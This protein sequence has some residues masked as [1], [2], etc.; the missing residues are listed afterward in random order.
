MNVI[1]IIF[2]LCL[3][4]VSI[5]RAQ[6]FT[7]IGH[8]G[9]ASIAPE[10]TLASF[11][12][13]IDL[14]VDYF[15]LDVRTTLDDSLIIMHDEYVDRTTNGVGTVASKTYSEIKT[16]DAGSKFSS[17]FAGEKVP[18]LC[19][20]LKLAKDFNSKACLH[21]YVANMAKVIELVRNMG[22]QKSVM[23]HSF[24]FSYLQQS[25]N[26]DSTIE[27]LLLADFATGKEA[28]RVDSIHGEYI[29]IGENPKYTSINYAHYV[30]IKYWAWTVDDTAS[31][32]SAISYKVDGIITNYPQLLI[33][34]RNLLNATEVKNNGLLLPDKFSLSQNYPN[35]FNPSTVINFQIP[36]HNHVSLKIYDVIGKEVATLVD[37]LKGPGR[38]SVNFDASILSGGIYFAQLKSSEKMDVKKMMLIK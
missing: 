37:E 11:K 4:A 35:P 34:I 20:A 27:V 12:K 28:D 33:P 22:M 17:A 24:V 32:K 14:G 6:T 3:G 38:Y 21:I 26:L 31:M 5:S 36:Q 1:K 25:K 19:E 7:I 23:I 18:S 8:R 30:G 15:E 10:N 16:L 2:I 29:G 9:A 13:A